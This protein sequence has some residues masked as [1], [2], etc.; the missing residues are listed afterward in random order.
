MTV[1]GV[2]IS[3]P[4]PRV[5]AEQLKN[6]EGK[7]VTLVGKV[8]G[9][10]ENG[11]IKVRAADDGV[12]DIIVRSVI[13]QDLFV[14]VEGF[15]ENATTIREESI[16]GFGTNFGTLFIHLLFSFSLFTHACAMHSLFTKHGCRY[17]QL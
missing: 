3:K 4:A 7:R 15:V 6:F 17:G 14:E 8:D 10:F 2:D 12:V 5:N 16:I 9:N 13:P 11:V 1:P